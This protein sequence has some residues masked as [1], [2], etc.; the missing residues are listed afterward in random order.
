MK[1]Q[2][3]NKTSLQQFIDTGGGYN[4]DDIVAVPPKGKIVLNFANEKVFIE[5][6]KKYKNKLILRKL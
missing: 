6:G 4:P 5:N 3:I 2:I 1:V